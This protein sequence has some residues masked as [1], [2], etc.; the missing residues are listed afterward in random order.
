[1]PG[2][3][4]NTTVVDACVR[5]LRA[6][7][8]YAGGATA[9]AINGR[10]LTV[11]EVV[12]I[13]DEC[14]A[15]RTDLAQKRAVARAAMDRRATAE[16]ARREA[17]Q[18]LR[19]WVANEFGIASKEA[20]DFGFPPPKKPELTVDAKALAVARTKATRAARH[21]MGKRQKEQIRGTLAETPPATPAVGERPWPPVS[22]E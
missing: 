21:T 19:G 15:S 22:S 2:R 14:L 6:L 13:Y 18:A 11:A 7:A 10:K 9:I 20:I 16:A 5:R 12:A 3:P 17:D 4:N 8:S 1:M